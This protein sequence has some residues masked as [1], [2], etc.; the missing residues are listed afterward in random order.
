MLR[1]NPLLF[2]WI[3]TFNCEKVGSDDGMNVGL[4][5]GEDE[6]EFD[7][8]NDSEGLLEGQDDGEFDG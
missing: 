5:D 8:C 3:V 2:A 6:G 1:H 7:G 4:L